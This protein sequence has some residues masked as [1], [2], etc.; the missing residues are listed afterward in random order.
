[1][2]SGGTGVRSSTG[3]NILNFFTQFHVKSSDIYKFVFLF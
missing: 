3:D 1:M 2:R